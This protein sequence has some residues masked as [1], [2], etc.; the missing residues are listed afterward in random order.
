MGP[1]TL[2]QI[3]LFVS[4]AY[5]PNNDYTLYLNT[6]GI[7]TGILADFGAAF[8]LNTGLNL[9][10]HAGAGTAPLGP[11]APTASYSL[12]VNATFQELLTPQEIQSGGSV[13]IW[14]QPQSGD[15]STASNWT[16]SVLPAST[17]DTFFDTGSASPYTVALTAASSS[18]NMVLW[19]DNVTLALGGNNLSIGGILTVD[20]RGS[21]TGS[22]AFSGTGN[23]S[24]VGGVTVTS[25]G[26]LST[27]GAN[28]TAGMLNNA[29]V[30]TLTGPGLVTVNGSATNSGTITLAGDMAVNGDFTN[31]GTIT[32]T[33]GTHLIAGTIEVAS[34]AYYAQQGGVLR[35]ENVP[36]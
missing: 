17:I 19:G 26:S 27:G 15:W 23:V 20:G 13:S 1:G 29:G 16:Q 30:F 32:Q 12:S 5:A 18:G 33:S 4:S 34:G 14:A 22:L 10:I 6:N 3:F 8:P 25:A 11:S 36:G 28:L 21:Q 9:Q 31:S 7:S 2:G 24:T 35:P